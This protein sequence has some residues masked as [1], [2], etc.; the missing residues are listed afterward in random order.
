MSLSYVDYP[1]FNAVPVAHVIH[2]DKPKQKKVLYMYDKIVPDGQSMIDLGE[3]E[4][5]EKAVDI[6]QER[7]VMYVSGMSGAGKSYYCKQFIEKYHKKFPKREVVVFSSLDSCGT[8]DKLKYLKRIKIHKPEFMTV[9]LTAIDFKDKLVL[10]D[11][12]DVISNRK[13]KF[14]VYE[15]MNSILQI[16]RHHNVT[17]LVTSHS[18]TNGQETKII[19]NE[20]TAITLFPKSSGNRSLLY[21]AD[22]Y[23]GMDTKQAKE[24]KKVQGRFVTIVR[25]HPRCIFSLK[26]SIHA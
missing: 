16:G 2:E 5:F 18:V 9:P 10:F 19:L 14:K 20:A 21:I 8:L 17:A 7:E 15:I 24:L 4:T 11:D 13:I 3:D 23:L 6:S 22:A 12:I 1:Q 26:K 25:A